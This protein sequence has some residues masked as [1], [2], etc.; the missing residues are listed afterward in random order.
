MYN[1]VNSSTVVGVSVVIAGVVYLGY[2]KYSSQSAPP[3]PSQNPYPPT[4]GSRRR[5]TKHNKSRKYK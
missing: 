4:G 3:E 2:S 5:S 1:N